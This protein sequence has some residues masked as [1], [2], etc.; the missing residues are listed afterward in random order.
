MNRS[1]QTFLFNPPLN[2][3]EEGKWLLAVTLFDCTNSVFNITNE[4]NSFSVNIP[5]HWN[6]NFAEQT[7]DNLNKLIEL[8]SQNGIG[9]HVQEVK[10]RGYQKTTGDKEYKL[11]DFF[12]FKE[13]IFEGLKNVKYNDPEDMVYRL[14]LNYDEIIKILNFKYVP[15]KRIGDSL[16][17][18]IYQINDINKT[19]KKYFTR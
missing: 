15:T 7:I 10:K 11:S 9:L 5:G 16:K 19:P 1:K 18:D 17:P 8:S 2:L 14:Q 4:N 13:E 12:T 6:S 3:I